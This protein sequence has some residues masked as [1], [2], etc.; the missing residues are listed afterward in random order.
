VA[1]P[2]G[3]VLLHDV[4]DRDRASNMKRI[5][6]LRPASAVP[7]DSPLRR[8]AGFTHDELHRL[9][10]VSYGE[11]SGP[12]ARRGRID[13]TYDGIGNLLSQTTPPQGQSGHLAPRE[14]LAFGAFVHGGGTSGR[15]GRDP[16]DPPGPHAV[17][18]GA[19]G[20]EYIHDDRGNTVGIGRA[21]LVWDALNRLVEHETDG[22]ISSYAYD[23]AGQRVTGLVTGGS[24]DELTLWPSP[25]FE[26]RPGNA[27]VKYVLAGDRRIARVKGALDP[28]AARVQR[29]W[30]AGGWN[31][32]TVAVQAGGT[33]AAAC[34][35]RR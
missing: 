24:Q 12:P 35:P 33:A 21:R 31:A 18:L 7:L 5:D 30:L 4:Y 20:R 3:S 17:T 11:T 15:V 29:I 34:V 10:S 26:V 28:A 32:V 14:D 22:V 25:W 13:Y 1:G 9:T 2:D 6:D 23:H 8:S 19:D 16:G 27:P